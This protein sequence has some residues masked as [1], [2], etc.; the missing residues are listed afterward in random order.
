MGSSVC[1]E[2]A[3]IHYPLK[4]QCF[5]VGTVLISGSIIIRLTHHLTHIV[6]LLSLAP[7][8]SHSLTLSHSPLLC[9][10]LL[11][12]ELRSPL[13]FSPF[14]CLFFP[15]SYLPLILLHACPILPPTAVPLS[16]SFTASHHDPQTV[17]LSPCSPARFSH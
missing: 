17:C 8:P 6:L 10:S 11:S 9:S 16:L 2:P 3:G 7:S 1:L 4:H 15:P 14:N 5:T 13:L 12:V